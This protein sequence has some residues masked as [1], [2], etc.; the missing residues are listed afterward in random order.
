MEWRLK[1]DYKLDKVIKSD[2]KLDKVIVS[3]LL[4]PNVLTM[5]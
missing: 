2:S 3:R 1:S 4:W 5:V